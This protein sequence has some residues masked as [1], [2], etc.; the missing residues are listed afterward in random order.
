MSYYDLSL[1]L[2]FTSQKLEKVSN[3]TSFFS[4]L[5]PDFILAPLDD[6]LVL[7]HNCKIPLF[8][9]KETTATKQITAKANLTMKTTAFAR[10]FIVAAKMYVTTRTTT[11]IANSSNT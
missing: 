4:F 9:R 5:I 1:D 11:V 10:I 7:L 8:G 6:C 3:K 2:D